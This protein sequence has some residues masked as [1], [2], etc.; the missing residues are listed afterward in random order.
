MFRIY[1][2]I[3]VFI[4][5]KSLVFD[6][7][8]NLTVINFF[9][10]YIGLV[11]ALYKFLFKLM[12]VSYEE[13]KNDGIYSGKYISLSILKSTNILRNISDDPSS[14]SS[15]SVDSDLRL[16][17]PAAPYQIWEESDNESSHKNN[18]LVFPSES[19]NQYN[20][21]KSY[22]KKKQGQVNKESEKEIVDLCYIKDSGK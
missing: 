1:F 19:S 17:S 15:F 16:N 18:S 7:I 13:S 20:S 14:N 3:P 9:A 4:K 5:L 2:R 12:S 8:M 21:S 11:F 10:I 6:R 22:S